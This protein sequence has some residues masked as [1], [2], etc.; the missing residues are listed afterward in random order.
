MEAA[1][2]SASASAARERERDRVPP[3]TRAR[4]SAWFHK[5]WIIYTAVANGEEEEEDG[6]DGW[7]IDSEGIFTTLSLL[8][9]ACPPARLPACPPARSSLKLVI[10]P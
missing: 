2:S 4:V 6:R 7:I 1:A 9:P 10:L 3:H 8:P 5:M